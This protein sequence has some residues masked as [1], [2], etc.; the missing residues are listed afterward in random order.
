M[1]K[2]C[3]PCWIDRLDPFMYSEGRV[4]VSLSFE[5]GGIK[6]YSGLDV[7]EHVEL[8]VV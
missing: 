5:I 8:F 7:V 3:S 6:S 1:L 4:L 2:V